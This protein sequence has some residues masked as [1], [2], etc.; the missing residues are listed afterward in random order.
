MNYH[1]CTSVYSSEW[2]RR[3]SQRSF[4][5]LVRESASFFRT[6]L[7]TVSNCITAKTA[8]LPMWIPTGPF[9][10]LCGS[11]FFFQ[12]RTSFRFLTKIVALFP[13]HF[14][15]V[16]RCVGTTCYCNCCYCYCKVTVILLP[17]FCFSERGFQ[18]KIT[19]TRRLVVHA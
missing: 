1:N 5:L 10:T 8:M 16:K 7:W 18:G 11:D 6:F 3:V 2:R 17:G 12:S 14:L 19:A 4:V 15:F 9:L 13:P